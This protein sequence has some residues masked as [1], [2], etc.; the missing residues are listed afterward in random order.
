[1]ETI[2]M[3]IQENTNH[4]IFSLGVKLPLTYGI[5]IRNSMIV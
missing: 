1:M 2:G 3:R 5:E 4:L